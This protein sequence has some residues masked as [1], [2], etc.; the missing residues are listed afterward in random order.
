MFKQIWVSD[1]IEPFSYPFTSYSFEYHADEIWINGADIKYIAFLTT[2]QSQHYNTDF[3]VVAYVHAYQK[4]WPSWAIGYVFI[5]GETGANPL[6]LPAAAVADLIGL[7]SNQYLVSKEVTESAAGVPWGG[8]SPDNDALE[9]SW[10]F[11]TLDEIKEQIIQSFEKIPASGVFVPSVEDIEV[12][13]S[14]YSRIGLLNFTGVSLPKSKYGDPVELRRVFVDEYNDR[15]MRPYDS[16]IPI[17]KVYELASGDFVQDIWVSGDPEQIFAE[18]DKHAYVYCRNGMLDLI[19][20]IEGRVV[21]SY[22]AP[23]PPDTEYIGVGI[24]QQTFCYERRLRRLISL[25]VTARE[26]ID[27]ASYSTMR[28]RG[29]YPVPLPVGLSTPIPLKPP[30]K[31]KKIPVVVRLHGDILEPISG[32]NVSATVDGEGELTITNGITNSRGEVVLQVIGGTNEAI[33][34]TATALIADNEAI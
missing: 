23:F 8:R 29:Y 28:A 20:Y 15:L 34:L 16:G 3:Q 25:S 2:V 21:S 9:L 32:V 26:E 7:K 22:R 10:L 24:G 33:T 31:G 12:N 17:V 6:Y 18:S 13:L 14:Y 11:V 30:R 5:N 4:N 27:G 19:N 1:K